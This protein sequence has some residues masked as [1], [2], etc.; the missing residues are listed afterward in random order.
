MEFQTPYNRG[1]F[2]FVHEVNSGVQETETA[3]YIPKNLQ[4]R[5]MM[6]AGERLDQWRDAVYDF[7][8]GEPVNM[9]FVDPTRSPGFDW[10]DA[11]MLLRIAEENA[12]KYK[13]AQLELEE[14]RRSE[15]SGKDVK[16]P[17]TSENG[18]KVQDSSKTDV[19]E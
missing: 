7:K 19:V 16:I 5:Q 10:S 11:S 9:D 12:R 14:F 4:I 13:E 18:Q 1:K 15:E 6:L 2:K 8:P 17:Q 3:G